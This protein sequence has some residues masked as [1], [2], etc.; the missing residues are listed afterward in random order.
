VIYCPNSIPIFFSSICPMWKMWSVVDLLLWTPSWWSSVIHNNY[1]PQW[2]LSQFYDPSSKQVRQQTPSTT[3]AIPHFLQTELMSLWIS[4]PS[5]IS[6]VGILSVS[7]DFYIFNLSIAISTSKEQTEVLRIQLHSVVET[8][9]S[10][11]C[12]KRCENL[13]A[14][15]RSHPSAS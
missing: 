2:L 6:S 11:S 10:S 9:N 5:W 15:H 14:D 3:E 12:T 1:I 13:Q 4:P 8:S 7:V